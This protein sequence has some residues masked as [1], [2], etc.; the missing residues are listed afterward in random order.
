MLW[1][2]IWL[3][4]PTV[5]LTTLPTLCP[6]LQ[7]SQQPYHLV[8]PPL[9][10]VLDS[11][12]GVNYMTRVVSQPRPD[13]ESNPRPLWTATPT[14]NMLHHHII[15]WHKTFWWPDDSRRK[16][17]CSVNDGRVTTTSKW[18][19]KLRNTRL[20]F[21]PQNEKNNKN[22]TAMYLESRSHYAPHVGG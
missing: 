15:H 17:C 12:K 20:Q 13:R 9:R 16:K 11:I 19:Q 22:N 5:S 14:P 3:A 2:I 21:D 1:C 10:P 18:R 7:S 4:V 6:T 8:R